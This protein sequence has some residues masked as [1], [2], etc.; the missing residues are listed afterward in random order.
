MEVKTQCASLFVA[1]SGYLYCSSVLED[2]VWKT[3]VD[4]EMEMMVVAGTG[5]DGSSDI[6]LDDPEGIFVDTDCDLSS[7]ITIGLSQ[8]HSVIL[9]AYNYLFIP[10]GGNNRIVASGLNGFRCLVGCDGGGTRSHQLKSPQRFRFDIYGNLFVVDK[11]NSRIQKFDL[12]EDSCVD[13][14]TTIR[15]TFSS[16]FLT[17]DHG[18]FAHAPFYSSAFFYEAIEIFVSQN[19]FY[20]LI[21]VSNIELYGY[22]YKDRFHPFDPTSRERCSNDRFEFTLELHVYTKYILVITTYNPFVTGP[23]SITVFG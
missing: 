22:V 17:E 9:D 4:N 14:P 8:P 12:L 6:E 15:A 1:S 5:R 19:G 3:P 11:G 21:G 2:I 10:D 23:F 18:R 13:V 20:I 16:T 7:D